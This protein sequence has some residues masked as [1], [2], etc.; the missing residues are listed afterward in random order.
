MEMYTHMHSAIQF[1]LGDAPSASKSSA[2]RATPHEVPE[3]ASAPAPPQAPDQE[4][5][6][7]KAPLSGLRKG[8]A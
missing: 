1:A 6:L 8:L 2:E 7:P 4:D 3:T 5:W